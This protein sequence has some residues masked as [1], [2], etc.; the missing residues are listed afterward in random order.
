MK[1]IIN[2]IKTLK[3]LNKTKASFVAQ[4]AKGLIGNESIVIG[5]TTYAKGEELES[6]IRRSEI[7]TLKEKIEE[8]LEKIR[9]LHNLGLIHN[10]LHPGNILLI[11]DKIKFIDFGRSTPSK[12]KIN[13]FITLSWGLSE[14]ANKDNIDRIRNM[15]MH[16]ESTLKKIDR[17]SYERYSQF[18]V[19]GFSIID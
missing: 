2:E 8:I 19:Y 18:K 11:R 3:I 17:K 9:E 1:E 4:E 15:L 16:L 14:I 7:K 10:D 13:D 6:F 5:I 12:N